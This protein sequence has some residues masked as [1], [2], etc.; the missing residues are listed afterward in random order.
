MGLSGVSR[1]SVLAA[2]AEYEQLGHEGLREYYGFGLAGLSRMVLHNKRYDAHT[3]ASLAQRYGAGHWP[4]PEELTG[5]EEAIAERL[6]QVGFVVERGAAAEADVPSRAPQLVLQPRGLKA[7]APRHFTD[8]VRDGVALADIEK[9][10]GEDAGLMRELYPG[11]TVWL[12]GSTPCSVPWHAK[13]KALEGR[14]VGDDVFFYHSHHFIARARILHLM[15]NSELARNVWGA[16]EEGETWEHVMA[17]GN[18]EHFTPAVSAKPVLSH[19]ALGSSLRSLTLKSA[20]DYAN[21]A[22]LFPGGGEGPGGAGVRPTT[23]T[24]PGGSTLRDRIAALNIPG[25]AKRV[26]AD[27]PESLALLWASSRIA[28]EK[29]RLLPLP[30]LREEMGPLLADFSEREAED[31]ANG[32]SFEWLRHDEL[33][34]VRGSLEDL[35]LEG[36]P[37]ESDEAPPIVGLSLPAAEK[38]KN[39]TTRLETVATLCRGALGGIDQRELLQRVG[40]GGYENAQGETGDTRPDDAVLLPGQRE[41]EHEETAGPAGRRKGGYSRIIRNSAYAQQVK[42]LH[43]GRCQVCGTQLEHGG[44]SFVQAAH[45]RGLGAPHN[46][47]D[48]LGNLLCLCPNDHALFDGFAIYVDEH[49]VVRRMDGGASPGELRRVSEHTIDASQVAYHRALCMLSAPAHQ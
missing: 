19:F 5:G 6:E 2:V 16:D 41:A 39:A 18:V 40:L 15:R 26:A 8:T 25:E 17:L 45:I 31:A 32:S 24:A 34:E 9:Y 36:A 23:A 13:T 10:L 14:R 22:S 20:S 29:P 27:R 7:G 28:K 12:W 4:L 21:A 33:W 30:R 1:P 35:S 11:G 49:W 37:E 3:I 44:R 38:L 47:P 43:G 48:V 42:E 46:G